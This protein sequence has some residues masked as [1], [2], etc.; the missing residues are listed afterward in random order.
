[1]IATTSSCT[2]VDDLVQADVEDGAT[3]EID[4]TVE[5]GDVFQELSSGLKLRCDDWETD[6]EGR[7]EK[8]WEVSTFSTIGGWGRVIPGNMGYVSESDLCDR[9]KYRLLWKCLDPGRYP[10]V[11]KVSV[12]VGYT[13]NGWEHTEGVQVG[14]AREGVGVVVVQAVGE[15]LSHVAVHVTSCASA[16]KTVLEERSG[17]LLDSK[18]Y[19][20][21]TVDADDVPVDA[22]IELSIT[23]MM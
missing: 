7:G 4:P 21:T 10:M 23:G 18:T 12:P 9:N 2:P 14:V 11:M 19:T 6:E 5:V 22:D 3:I 8:Y 1:M 15:D 13:R 20:F 17:L 16:Y